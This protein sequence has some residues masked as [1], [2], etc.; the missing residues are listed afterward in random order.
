MA[1]LKDLNQCETELVQCRRIIESV[2]NFYQLEKASMRRSDWLDI[3]A[4]YHEAKHKGE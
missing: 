3:V 1:N 2:D 4:E